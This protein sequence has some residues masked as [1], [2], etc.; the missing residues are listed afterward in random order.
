M[1]DV[2]NPTCMGQK[3]KAAMKRKC[4]SR[5]AYVLLPGNPQK[6]ES[7]GHPE[8]RAHRNQGTRGTPDGTGSPAS[9]RI[10][11]DTASGQ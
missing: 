3:D 9:G 2:H 1:T 10:Q 11:P 4:F 8:R 7:F 5:T 6:H